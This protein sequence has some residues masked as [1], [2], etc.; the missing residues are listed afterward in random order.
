MTMPSIFKWYESLVRPW[1]VPPNYVF[2]ISWSILYILMGISLYLV[3]EKG[4]SHPKVKVG[5]GF[6]GLQLVLNF[7]WTVF[8]FGMRSLFLGMVDAVL[9]WLTIFVTIC[10]FY[11]IS[12]KAAYLLIPYLLWVSF[13]VVMSYY[14]LVLN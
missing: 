3:W 12:K 2:A 5:I 7:L 9:L 13:A 11:G 4:L 14:F 6:F 10:Y 1:F 8:F